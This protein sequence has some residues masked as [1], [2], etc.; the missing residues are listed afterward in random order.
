MYTLSFLRMEEVPE[1]WKVVL[2]E[3]SFGPDDGTMHRW[4]YA[5]GRCYVS[6]LREGKT[7]LAWSCIT[8]SED[9][10]PVVGCYTRET[11]RKQGLG[12]ACAEHM[13]EVLDLPGGTC[14]YAVAENWTAWPGIIRDAGL[15]Y[16]EWV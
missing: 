9:T 8:Y 14:V 7:I 11:R 16:F 6:V 4:T 5:E 3:L 10:F 1:H 2:R 12:R 13:L 15:E